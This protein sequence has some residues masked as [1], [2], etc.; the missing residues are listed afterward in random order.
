MIKETTLTLEQIEVAITGY[1]DSPYYARQ[2]IVVP[3]CNW[4]FLNHEA[5]LLVMSKA[6]YLTEIEIKRTWADFMA[7]FK[8]RHTHFDK[9]LSHFYYAVPLSIGERVFNWLYEGAYRC[10]PS[11]IYRQQSTI[12]GYTEHNPHKCGLIVYASPEEVGMRINR[13]GACCINVPAHRMNDYKISPD[14]EMKLL[15]LLG[16]RIWSMKKKLAEY[17]AEPSLLKT[18][19]L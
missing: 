7:D 19:K 6:K 4:G 18:T 10:E 13:V 14:E 17:Q 3:N 9:K 2:N 16:L 11:W 8:K 12:T 5:D 15:R 1:P